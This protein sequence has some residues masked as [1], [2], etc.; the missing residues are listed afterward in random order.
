MRI[1]IPLTEAVA[2]RDGT[3]T[4]DSKIVN[5]F[6][7][8]RNKKPAVTKRFGLTTYASLP[9]GEG[10]GM[11]Y[12]SG[13]V[14][15]IIADK[16]YSSTGTNYPYTQPSILGEVYQVL[17]DIYGTSVFFKSSK[18]GYTFNG[19]TV[20]KITDANYPATTVPGIVYLDGTYYIMDT[21][22][23]LWGSNLDDPT[24]WSA[25]NEIKSN[26]VAG[27]PVALARYLNY[28]VAFKDNSIEFFYDAANALGSPLS[29]APNGLL[30]VGCASADSVVQIDN[31]VMF[32]SRTIQKGRSVSLMHGL[33]THPVSTPE[34]DR[35]LNNDDLA[36]IYS[37]SIK[38]Q[39]HNFY[40]LSL[41]TSKITVV[42]D[43][44]T[45]QWSIWTYLTPQ[46]PKTVSSLTYSNGIVTASITAH[47]LSD[48]DPI[49][50]A[51]SVQTQYNGT[52]S[53]SY[54]DANT[55]S[56]TPATTPSVSPA[57]GTITATTYVE[58]YLP[59]N[60]YVSSGS[61][62]LLLHEL[63][64]KI[65][66]ASPTSYMDDVS[67]INFE[68][69][70]NPFDMD[71]TDTKFISRLEL[72]GDKTSTYC[73]MRYTDDD[74]Q[75]YSLYRPVNMAS[76]RSQLLRNGATQRRA[77]QIKHIDNTACV[78]DFL[79]VEFSMEI[80]ETR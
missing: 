77:V 54:I 36:S 64:G 26:S 70:T 30:T 24:T 12:L 62:D 13:T 67:P 56:Y 51:G 9:V 74:Y 21:N 44:I 35:I 16:L 1:R 60:T 25:L 68:I 20:T 52:F 8:V 58:G 32:I 45:K 53:V 73:Y 69:V 43:L 55:L 50:I 29:P 39:G 10:Q 3:T 71:T 57:T 33:N 76:S 22:S 42:Y 34:I 11:F 15:A 78:V 6:L 37:F 65:Y 28:V 7:D 48:G 2:T 4:K 18:A 46:T 63:N 17:S 47:G 14:Y 38:I 41:T 27:V 72:V 79:D 66:V 19:T 31:E 5:G 23:S 49:T 61:Q 75:T 80:A 40:V 59:L